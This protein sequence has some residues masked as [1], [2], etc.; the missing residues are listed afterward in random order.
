MPISETIQDMI[1]HP[2]LSVATISAQAAKEGML[3]LQQAGL[4]QVIQGVTSFAE[5]NA[6]T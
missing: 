5:I 2:K 3:T 1:A 6:L 4:V